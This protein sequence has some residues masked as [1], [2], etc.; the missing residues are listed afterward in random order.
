MESN[1]RVSVCVP[2]YNEEPYLIQFLDSLVSQSFDDYEIILVDN[3]SMDRSLEIL[4]NYEERF[5]NKVFVYQTDAHGGSGKA[6]NLAFLKARGYYIYWCDADDYIHPNGLEILVSEATKHN[7]DI[8]CGYAIRVDEVDGEVRAVST[9]LEK[10]YM[11]A[12]KDA[13][14]LSGA[15]FWLRL[16]KR[17][18]IERVGLMPEDVVSGE[19]NYVTVLQSH[20]NSVRFVGF[21]VYY[22][23]RRNVVQEDTVEK[24]KNIVINAKQTLAD[25]DSQY[26]DVVQY[27]VALRTRSNLNINWPFFD[28]FVNWVREQ[29]NW[30]YEN[31]RL[32]SDRK[33]FGYLRWVDGLA[34]IQFLNIIYVDGFGAPPTNERMTDLREK[35]F[36]DGCEIV[37][38][39]E[40]TVILARIRTLNALT[41]I[42]IWNLS[43][44]TSH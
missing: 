25:C 42:G 10:K 29:A 36:H 12:S 32:L 1:P 44:S 26:L 3:H 31:N 38:L 11:N 39:N 20:A 28:V 19:A 24:A 17:S 33:L 18:L 35:V 43:P 40:K 37:I 34:D 23:Y 6:R 9:M 14:I 15:E 8:T 21:P 30:L 2:V 5:P 4:H 41:I 27:F 13:A 7:A 22:W 16:F